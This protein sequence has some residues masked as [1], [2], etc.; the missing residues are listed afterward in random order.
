MTGGSRAALL[1]L[2][3]DGGL[4]TGPSLAVHLGTTRWWRN[5]VASAW[6]S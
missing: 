5:C 3:A 4:H 2:L 6:M 1:A